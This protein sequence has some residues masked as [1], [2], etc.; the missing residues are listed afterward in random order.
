MRTRRKPTRYSKL[1][2]SLIAASEKVTVYIYGYCFPQRTYWT[3][4]YLN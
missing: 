4:I 3:I 1:L 2:L